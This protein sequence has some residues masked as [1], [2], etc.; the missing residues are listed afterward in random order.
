MQGFGGCRECHWNA[1]FQK[2]R[3]EFVWYAWVHHWTVAIAFNVR[4]ESLQ[5]LAPAN[6]KNFLTC[7][8]P[9]TEVGQCITNVHSIC[10]CDHVHE[11]ITQASSSAKVNWDVYEVAA[12]CEAM[13]IQEFKQSFPTEVVGQVEENDGRPILLY[14]RRILRDGGVHLGTVA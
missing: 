8:A 9:I 4:V 6:L 14:D 11:G 13:R 3:L 2:Q 12:I 10:M 1:I 7:H 5:L